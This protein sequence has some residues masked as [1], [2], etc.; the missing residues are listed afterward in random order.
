MKTT[1]MLLLALAVSTLSA[2]GGG[3]T[4]SPTSPIPPGTSQPAPLPPE[5][6]N[7]ARAVPFVVS[8][9][10]HNALNEPFVDREIR[11]VHETTGETVTTR[12][13]A[14][15][16]YSI[17]LPDRPG[18]WDVQIIY[19]VSTGAWLDNLPSGPDVYAPFPAAQGAIRNFAGTNNWN[20]YGLVDVSVARSDVELDESLELTLTPV[21]PNVFGHT[22]TLKIRPRA[23]LDKASR[24]IPQ[25]WYR[26]TATQTLRG[27][28]QQL[29]MSSKRQPTPG[30][31]VEAW[32]TDHSYNE[33][34]MNLYFHPL[35]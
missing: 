20:L 33:S 9:W 30:L 34:E 5:E 35:E 18:L 16:R 12:S 10:A 11:A 15:G 25:G 4:P 28:E 2:C 21:V 31:T 29:I 17:S 14:Q 23:S 24:R 8:G 22:E 13:D 32:F 7:E 1:R 3:G 27:E 26:V 6:G 19:A